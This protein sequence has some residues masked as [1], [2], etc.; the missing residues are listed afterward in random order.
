MHEKQIALVTGG[1]RGIGLEICRQLAQQGI[2][3]LL[4]ARSAEKAEAAADTLR[5]DG[6]DVRARVLDV[7]NADSIEALVSG[8]VAE[9]GRIDILVNNAGI[10]IDRGAVLSTTA[11][12]LRQTYETNIIGPVLLMQAV[13]PVMQQ[14]RRGRIVNVSSRMG[15]LT[16]MGGGSLGYRTSKAA[17]NA[18]TR[19][20]SAEF[21]GDGILINTC[22]PGW[23]QTDMGGPNASWTVEQ[24]ADTP[25]WLATLPDDGPTGGFFFDRQPLEW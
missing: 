23:V 4:T 25:V 11:D 19:A 16:H 20:F 12:Q 24:G 9:F 22:H 10:F 2:T 1:N 6:A 21:G 17:L 8:A 3:V 7:T 13:I 18:A 14:Q 5:H 15:S